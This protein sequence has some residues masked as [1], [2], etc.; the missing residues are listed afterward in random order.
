MYEAKK[1]WLPVSSSELP[2]EC[3][4]YVKLASIPRVLPEGLHDL[5]WSI[6][7]VGLP[8]QLGGMWWMLVCY[9]PQAFFNEIVCK[10]TN[11]SVQCPNCIITCKIDLTNIN[12]FNKATQ[13]RHPTGLATKQIHCSGAVCSVLLG[14]RLNDRLTGCLMWVLNIVVIAYQNQFT[15]P[16]VSLTC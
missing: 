9:I 13:W 4:F 14:Q 1:L 3:G 6:L 16:H 8:G 10:L 5:H 2:I 11:N 7:P 12:P 15:L